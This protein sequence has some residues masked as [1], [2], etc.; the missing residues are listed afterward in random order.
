LSAKKIKIGVLSDT[1]LNSVTDELRRIKTGYLSDVDY[2]LHAG[3]IVSMDVVA[4]LDDGNFFGVHGNM[5]S[6]YVQEFLPEKRIVEFGGVRLGL[7]HGWGA[8]TDLDDRVSREFRDVDV[9]VYGHT[10]VAANHLKDGVLFF[11]PG[12]AI[13]YTSSGP[14]TIGI[15]EIDNDVTGRIIEI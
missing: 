11:N 9:I 12:T 2:V 4:Y 3:D 13:G 10:H 7:I 15:L 5:D 6:F 8:K 14:H 1:H